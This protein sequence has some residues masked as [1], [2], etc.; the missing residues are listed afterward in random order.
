[1]ASK[2]FYKKNGQDHGPVS[3]TELK[4]LGA[5]NELQPSDLVW[6]EG[7]P[8]WLP[9]SRLA[10]LLPDSVNAMPPALPQA[11]LAST[12]ID[13]VPTPRTTGPPPIP[14]KAKTGPPPIPSRS[15]QP[16]PLPVR[17]ARLHSRRNKVLMASIVSGCV[18]LLAVGYGAYVR[19]GAKHDSVQQVAT[20]PLSAGPHSMSS[21]KTS[22]ADVGNWI[23]SGASVRNPPADSAPEVDATNSSLLKISIPDFSKID[24]SKGPNGEHLEPFKFKLVRRD[25]KFVRVSAQSGDKGILVSGEHYRGSE[26]Q[27]SYQG[28]VKWINE[29]GVSGMKSLP[30]F[31]LDMIFP[32]RGE[33]WFKAGVPHGKLT[34]WYPNKTKM[35]EMIYVEGQRQGPA[36]AWYKNGEKRYDIFFVDDKR[37]GKYIEWDDSGQKTDEG[38]Y[39]HGEKEGLS[40]INARAVPH[41]VDAFLNKLK[42]L[43]QRKDCWGGY[44]TLMNYDEAAFKATCGE[45]KPD[46]STERRSWDYPCS[47]GEVQLLRVLDSGGRLIVRDVDVQRNRNDVTAAL[48]KK[49][50]LTEIPSLL[51]HKATT[52]DVVNWYDYD[53]FVKKFGFPNGDSEQDPDDTSKRSWKFQCADGVIVLEVQLTFRSNEKVEGYDQ[54]YIKSVEDL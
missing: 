53:T 52:S 29:A 39:I 44:P 28:K 45:P 36:H 54:I 43:M 13:A 27:D 15:T 37:E 49:E 42:L 25:N 8:Q 31:A 7:M 14:P 40:D 32:G 5:K 24:Y 41:G 3:S 20:E 21:D 6:K 4:E 50:F 38:R 30:E 46:L 51:G 11:S 1:M 19:F 18:M 23:G 16:P 47:D 34:L 48:T 33:A 35:F 17:S 9:A 12:T 22:Q 2:W 10:G 26:G